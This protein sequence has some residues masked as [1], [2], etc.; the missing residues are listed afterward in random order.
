MLPALKRHL[1][2]KRRPTNLDQVALIAGHSIDQSNQKFLAR[3]WLSG[4]EYWIARC[5]N[6]GQLRPDLSDCSGLAD[7]QRQMRPAMDNM[8]SVEQ[9]QN[10]LHQSIAVGGGCFRI[11]VMAR[12]MVQIRACFQA[13][14]HD[15]Q[16]TL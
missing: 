12:M 11:L 8:R 1:W 10:L 2:P 14:G 15:E 13:I 9:F 7:E 6:T 3:A 16:G 5:G 4:D